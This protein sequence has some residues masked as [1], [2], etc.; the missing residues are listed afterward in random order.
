MPPTPAAARG[1]DP[2]P[3][4]V[5][6]H[7]RSGN[8]P[9]EKKKKHKKKKNK[10]RR[11]DGD[12]SNDH[13]GGAQNAVQSQREPR[14][15][16]ASTSTAAPPVKA[17]PPPKKHKRAKEIPVRF[18]HPQLDSELRRLRRSWLSPGDPLFQPAL[19]VSYRG[20]RHVPADALPQA[21]HGGF[22]E[23]FD[24][25]HDAGLFMYDTVQAGGKRLSKTFVTRTL[26]GDPGI[27]YKAREGGR[28]FG[29]ADSKRAFPVPT[30]RCFCVMILIFA[31]FGIRMKVALRRDRRRGCGIVGRQ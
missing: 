16:M 14:D 25:L 12:V 6:P 11:R 5:C 13:A 17:S 27:T 15:N 29:A 4:S 23:S 18:A 8:E 30:G 9:S 31:A 19:D 24:G 7:Q 22:R 1:T 28:F 20:M 10:K 21:I 2:T 3:P 26:L